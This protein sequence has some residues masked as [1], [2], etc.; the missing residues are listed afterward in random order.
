MHGV[1]KQTGIGVQV[2]NLQK[3]GI[4]ITLIQCC[5]N[6][7]TLKQR[8]INVISTPCLHGIY[9]KTYQENIHNEVQGGNL[10]KI[11]KYIFIAVH[12]LKLQK[13]P[14]NPSIP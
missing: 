12:L 6:V 10:S 8:W 3:R 14:P 11:T 2:N 5:F 9:L 7:T 1:H 4:E 13:L